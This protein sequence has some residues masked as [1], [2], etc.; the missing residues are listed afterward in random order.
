MLERS[1][2]VCQAGDIQLILSWVA[3][4]LG[5]AYALS[6]RLAEALPLL[7]QVVEQCAATKHMYLYPLCVAHLGEAYLLGGCPRI[8]C[9]DC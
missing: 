3:S 9:T 2:D 6:G 5:Y 4:F 1:L 7:E 8:T